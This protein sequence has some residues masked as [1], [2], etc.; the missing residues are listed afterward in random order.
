MNSMPFRQLKSF[1]KIL[2]G[3][4]YENDVIMNVRLVCMSC[5]DK[6]ILPL[7]ETHSELLANLICFLRSD[8]T[9]FEGLPDLVG[10]HIAFLLSADRLLVLPFGEHEVFIHSKWIALVLAKGRFPLGIY[11]RSASSS[12]LVIFFRLMPRVEVL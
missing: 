11:S 7:C 10:D 1:L 12:R 9:W 6:G 2:I 3:V 4:Q 5:N 8:L